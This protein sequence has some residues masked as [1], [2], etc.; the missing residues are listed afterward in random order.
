MALS[1]EMRRLEKKWKS[2]QGWPKRLL[3][4]KINGLRGWTGQMVHFNFPIVAI[5]GENG[6]GKSTVLQCAA[7]VYQPVKGKT[8]Y[9]TDF[10]PETGW[11]EIGN[12]SVAY[13]A[14]EGDRKTAKELKKLKRWRGYSGRPEREVDFFD[15]SRLQPLSARVGYTKLA[16][17]LGSA[18]HKELSSLAFD[19][20]TLFRL[21]KIMAKDYEAA[22]L[23]TTDADRRR[24]VPVLTHGGVISSGF[25]HGAGESIMREL[26]ENKFIKYGL[27]LIDEIEISLHPRVQ[28]R[29]IADLA[30]LARENDLQ[31]I[32]T[33]HSPIILAELPDE[34]RI[35]IMQPL[36]GGRSVIYGV[37][38]E[39]AMTKMDDVQHSNCEIFTEDMRGAVM[40]TEIIAAS[41]HPEIIL[42][43]QISACGPASVGIQL[44]QMIQ[45]GR[46]SRK[47]AVFL[48]GDQELM[49]GCYLLPGK[50]APE[51]VVFD[52]LKTHAWKGVAERIG[53]E[54]SI[55]V[56]HCQRAMTN[57]DHHAWVSSAATGLSLGG[58]VLWQALCSVWARNVLSQDDAKSVYEAISDALAGDPPSVQ[59]PKPAV[60]PKP[61]PK[62]AKPVKEKHP[63]PTS[64][65]SV[66]S[67]PRQLSLFSDPD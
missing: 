21:N 35:C 8:R 2:G 18:R 45:N 62:V 54:H 14:T 22:T 49:P 59:S 33:T 7:S 64:P 47:V 57:D 40:L 43:C 11:D 58:D 48:D 52:G 24:P 26:L 41:E 9:P 28:R 50:D 4:L 51:R 66:H 16:K 46:W 12:A 53:R 27:V 44:G 39:W 31:I 32:I 34:A 17:K 42:T 61:Q 67:Q 65:P 1:P 13:E 5:V 55:I 23:T 3:S 30:D 20:K 63:R 38:P 29:L 37:S 19:E 15:L 56:D 36:T 10:F 6:V 60:V 25:H